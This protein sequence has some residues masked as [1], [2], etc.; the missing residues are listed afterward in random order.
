MCQIT[1]PNTTRFETTQTR[2]FPVLEYQS[3][4]LHS[5]HYSEHPEENNVIEIVLL[6]LLTIEM[7]QSRTFVVFFFF[8]ITQYFKKT[9]F[10]VQKQWILQRIRDI[11][12][13][14]RRRPGLPGRYYTLDV[15]PDAA[16]G[17]TPTPTSASLETGTT[18]FNRHCRRL[19]AP[20]YNIIF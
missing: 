2:E 14:A 9:R 10:K 1:T 20:K 3:N 7:K 5:G 11:W 16:C 13:L 12:R 17:V 8:Q 19:H 4:G 18:A 15:V 6:T